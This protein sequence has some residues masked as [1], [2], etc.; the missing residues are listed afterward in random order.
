MGIGVQLIKE[1]VD[2]S[3]KLWFRYVVYLNSSYVTVGSSISDL[4][5]RRTRLS[6]ADVAA[7]ATGPALAR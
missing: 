5:L 3:V 6:P 2:K 1:S 7:F 4:A